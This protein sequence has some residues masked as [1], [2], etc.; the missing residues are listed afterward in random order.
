M[1]ALS[2]LQRRR[3]RLSV[4][5]NSDSESTDQET[6]DDSDEDSA[7]EELSFE[8][9]QRE[10]R[11]ERLRLQPAETE[12]QGSQDVDPNTGLTTAYAAVI[13]TINML[14]R[15]LNGERLQQPQLSSR[16]WSC[17]SRTGPILQHKPG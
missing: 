14:L 6:D 13:A 8:F 17:P 11:T 15:R 7:E 4:A 12:P 5:E 16:A 1:V 10:D 3:W 9:I 2:E